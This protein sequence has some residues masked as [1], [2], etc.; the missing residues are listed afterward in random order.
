MAL[1]V[2]K[3]PFGYRT[4][5]T[6]DNVGTVSDSSGTA[7]FTC[8]SIHGLAADDHVY[9]YSPIAGYSGWWNVESTPGVNT[10]TLN[11]YSGAT[12]LEFIGVTT[13]ILFE[14]DIV[15]DPASTH[16]WNSVHLPIIYKLQ[17]TIWPINGV[18]TARTIT[19]FTNYNGYTYI[20]ASGDIKSSGVAATLE[21]VVLS[22]TSVDGVYKIIQ[23]FSDTNFVIDLAYSAGNVLSSG[24]VQYYYLN[25]HAKVKVYAG[26]PSG[27]YY[28][29]L[30][31]FEQVAE[32][33]A[34]PDST[35]LITLNVNEYVKKQ[36]DVFKNDTW[37]LINDVGAWCRL[38][39]S[40]AE[41]YNDSNGYTVTEVTS[42]YTD[43]TATVYA[44]NVMPPFK[45]R[46]SGNISTW[47]SGDTS[48]TLMDFLTPF[49][50]PTIFSGYY[51]DLAYINNDSTPGNYMKI[52][53]YGADRVLIASTLE[54]IPDYDQGIYRFE[55]SVTGAEETIDVTHYNVSAVQRSE[56]ITI[57]V[58]DATYCHDT[59][60]IYLTWKNSLGGHDYWLFKAQKVYAIDTYENETE[61]VNIYNNWPQSY[62]EFAQTIKAQTSR[63][64]KARITVSSQFL[65]QEQADAIALIKTSGL[66]QV[67]EMSSAELGSV[68]L[69]TTVLV[70]DSPI[71]KYKDR[72]KTF[73]VSFDIEFTNDLPVQSL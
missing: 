60:P 48:D 42:S 59:V 39:I 69:Y 37:S 45:D 18:D 73:T 28:D 64:S 67:V 7:L 21:N 72:D 13:F 16:R 29:H 12:A 2:V 19:T 71:T 1:S 46:D 53:R 51:F 6:H 32:I 14:S 26:F 52:D 56:T 11:D 49:S 9:I 25:Y 5:P 33:R 23:W 17:S 66:V 35:G 41:S 40:Y 54:T 44:A 36:I 20:V 30:K 61:D 62:G 55:L 24:T 8:D 38:Y 70:D 3:Y 22:G 63:K 65:T 4:K 10:L 43:D 47:V 68:P 15:G 34:V 58:G 27:H 31:P 57:D 50:Q